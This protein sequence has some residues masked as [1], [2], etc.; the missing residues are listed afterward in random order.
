MKIAV[1]L[2]ARAKYSKRIPFKPYVKLG[3]KHLIEY[4]LEF[5]ERLPFQRHVYLDYEPLKEV[6][7]NYNVEIHDKILESE[8][9]VHRTNEEL[10]EYNKEINADVFIL[11]QCTSPFRSLTKVLNALEEFML[12]DF[13]CAMSVYRFNRYIYD[14]SGNKLNNKV[15]SYNKDIKNSFVETGS[16]YIFR[17]EQLY[18]EHITDGKRLLIEDKFDIDIDTLEDLKNVENKYKEAI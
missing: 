18:K 6:A 1:V 12:H 9:G 13:D 17:K 4:T 8:T 16:F 14:Q 11:L 5:M 7:K 2:L 15:R 3:S 10:L